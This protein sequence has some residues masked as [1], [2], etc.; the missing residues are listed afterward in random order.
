MICNHTQEVGICR[1]ENHVLV[2]TPAAFVYVLAQAVWG[3]CLPV[4]SW[5]WQG[6]PVRPRESLWRGHGPAH[7]SRHFTLAASHHCLLCV[8]FLS[9][10][11]KFYLLEANCFTILYW[12]LPNITRANHPL[13]IFPGFANGQVRSFLSDV[14]GGLRTSPHCPS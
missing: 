7:G 12:F 13:C 10:F 8:S 9:F 11:F 14:S 6:V 2:W 5:S 3:A 4:G 1:G